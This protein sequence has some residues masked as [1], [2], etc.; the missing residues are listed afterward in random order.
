MTADQ[1]DAKRK[2][3]DV[4]MGANLDGGRGNVVL[5]IGKTTADPL[6]QGER[7]FGIVSLN[8][9]TGLPTGSGTTVPAAFSTGVGPGGNANTLSGS[10][11]INPA[12]GV[13]VQPAQL[14][15][16]NPPNYYQTGLQRTQATA[17]GN[18]K[19]NDYAEVYSEI[20]A[21]NSKVA[22]ALASTGTF[23]NTFNVPIGN[24][25]IP[26]AARE[27]ICA[28]RGIPAAS[29]VAGNATIVPLLVNRRFTELGPRYNDFDNK[30][31]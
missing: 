18:Y 15:N 5:S 14:Y 24:P 31:L 20:F 25:Y 23:G 3:T 30:T 10:W 27:Q 17:L 29:C 8:S 28:R 16:T 7:D 9:V 1:H 13:L 4:T 19:I 11:Q 26:Q 12:T 22:S 2:R 21:T 6:T